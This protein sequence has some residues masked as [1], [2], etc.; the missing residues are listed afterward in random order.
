VINTA[1]LA[2]LIHVVATNLTRTVDVD[3]AVLIGRVVV[4]IPVLGSPVDADP[5]LLDRGVRVIGLNRYRAEKARRRHKRSEQYS[6][7]GFAGQ[8]L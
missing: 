1:E 3:L 8:F 6:I 5:S 4:A 2:G 7:E